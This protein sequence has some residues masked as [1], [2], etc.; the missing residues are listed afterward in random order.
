MRKL[1]W[2][3]LTAVFIAI[4]APNASADTY[5]FDFACV[6]GTPA[7]ITPTGSFDYD[8]TTQ[9]FSSIQVMWNGNTF[10]FG[11]SASLNGSLSSCYGSDTGSTA[12]YDLL[13]TCGPSNSVPPSAC[14]AEWVGNSNPSTPTFTF[15]DDNASTCGFTFTLSAVSSGGTTVEDGDYS[16][17]SWSCSSG[18]AACQAGGLPSVPEPASVVLLLIVLTMLGKRF[19]RSL[20]TGTTQS[21]S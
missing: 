15:Q 4:L 18:G 19:A 6:S 10:N 9:T 11:T 20:N 21:P 3:A 14:S 17:G 12:V 5:T 16:E 8:P 1:L 7:C 2:I 13:G